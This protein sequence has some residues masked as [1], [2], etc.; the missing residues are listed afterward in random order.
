MP[1]AVN[2]GGTHRREERFLERRLDENQALGAPGLL[3]SG[4]GPTAA[5]ML[6]KPLAPL[7]FLRGHLRRAFKVTSPSSSITPW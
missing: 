4:W 6:G 2:S 1:P 7:P 5:R 3:W